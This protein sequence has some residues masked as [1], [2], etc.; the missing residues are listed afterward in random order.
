MRTLTWK[1]RLTYTLFYPLI[2]GIFTLIWATCRKQIIGDEN[3]Q[4]L[5]Q[6]KKPFLP[7]Y[8]HQQHLFCAWYIRQLIRRGLKVGFLVSPSVDGE[9]PAKIARSW[10]AQVIRGSHNRTG[11]KAMRDLYTWICKDGL[12]IINT[13]DGPTGPAFKFKPGAIMLAQ[14]TGAPLL[15]LVYAAE[16]AWHLK[17]WDRFIIPKPFS[18]ICIVIGQPVTVDKKTSPAELAGIAGK[19]EADM[20]ELAKQADF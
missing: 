15:P 6:T 4:A 10:G 9:I 8:W 14:L 18:H 16:N 7:C 19:I 11:A 5:L 12:S 17:S 13:P 3:A 2:K 20:Q 1:R